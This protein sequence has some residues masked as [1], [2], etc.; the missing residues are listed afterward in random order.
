MTN[1]NDKWIES[2]LKQMYCNGCD[3]PYMPKPYSTL[4]PT[5][6]SNYE[7]EML[8]NDARADREE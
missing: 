2:R 7:T 1:L 6:G 4:C 3:E 8:E 5:C